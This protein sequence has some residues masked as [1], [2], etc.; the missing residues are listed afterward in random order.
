MHGMSNY[1]NKYVLNN[2]DNEFKEIDI[3]KQVCQEIKFH[4]NGKYEKWKI[5]EV[6]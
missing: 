6:L 1:S 2:C 4:F 5:I 3:T